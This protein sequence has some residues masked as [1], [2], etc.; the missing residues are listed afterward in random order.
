MNRSLLTYLLILTLL[1]APLQGLSKSR[2]DTNIVIQELNEHYKFIPDKQGTALAKV[3]HTSKA[4]FRA[5]RVAGKAYAVAYYNDAIKVDNVGGYDVTT[6]SYFGEDIFFSDSKACLIEVNLK[7]GGATS[8]ASYRQTYTK[9]EH[10]CKVILV[11]RYDIEQA[12]VSFEIPL[13]L[14]G[15]YTIEERNIPAGSMTKS[16]QTK[17]DKKIV[18]YTFRDIKAP[19]FFSD[20]PSI[21]VT[22]PQLVV[23]GHYR[24]LGE[25]YRYLYGYV[26]FNDPDADAVT[27][28]A[29]ELT[30]DCTTDAQRID[31]L[32]DFVHNNIRYV[33][34]EHGD[35]SHRPDHPSEVLRKAYGDCKGSAML[36]RSMLRACGIDA[37][38]VWTGTKETGDTWSGN[39]S[40]SSGDHM[41]AAVMTGDS[42]M[43]IDGTARHT[44]A[45]A[46]PYGLQG[47]EAL[48]ENGAEEYILAKMPVSAPGAD[49]TAVSMDL[50]IGD[51]GDMTAEGI[52]T[53]KGRKRDIIRSAMDRIVP[54]RLNRAY[55]TLFSALFSNCI[56]GKATYEDDPVGRTAVIAG[57][58]AVKGC[59]RTIADE[60]YVEINPGFSVLPS[61]SFDMADRNVGGVVNLTGCFDATFRLAMPEGMTASAI[62]APH[63]AESDWIDATLT[64]ALDDDGRQLTRRLQITVKNPDVAFEDLERFNSL[65]T[66]LNRACNEKIILIKKK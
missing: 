61:M 28:K 41:I 9:P 65:V 15:Q 49:M 23:R 31:A 60:L 51:T 35:L 7:K 8:D 20:A 25:L 56:T 3:E 66:G 34:V 4:T 59:V 63:V 36:L 44:A 64:T 39:P 30:A 10:F 2:T 45:G 62:P 53:F 40:L 22:A 18:S 58:A 11:D 17:G 42:I 1:S 16:T 6:G 48:I 54:E 26:D 29:R 46:I 24:D 21:N 43:Y 50:S 33:A 38:L 52:V 13:S 32:T 55:E 19:S 47:R 14:A 37:R 5:Q 57:S 27:T 12:N